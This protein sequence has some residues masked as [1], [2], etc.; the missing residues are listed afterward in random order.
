MIP[1]MIPCMILL[2]HQLRTCTPNQFSHLHNQPS[3]LFQT[4]T[5]PHNFSLLVLPPQLVR[6]RPPSWYPLYLQKTGTATTSLHI[7]FRPTHTSQQPP[8]L[9]Q[10]LNQQY[11]LWSEEVG[12][13]KSGL[14]PSIH[15]QKGPSQ[16]QLDQLMT[17]TLHPYLFSQLTLLASVGLSNVKKEDLIWISWWCGAVILIIL[18][19]GKPNQNNRPARR[20]HCFWS[21]TVIPKEKD[22]NV[23]RRWVIW[24]WVPMS[25]FLHLCVA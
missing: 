13:Q 9:S 23:G 19:V 18:E 4:P 10:F 15:R 8:I 7:S 11:N 20:F 17:P 22:S 25:C 3:P 14:T 6:V 2:P 5:Y 12:L 16:H 21:V 24:L 1:C